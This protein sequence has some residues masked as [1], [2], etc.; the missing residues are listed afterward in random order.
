MTF[1]KF[2]L[3][4]C[5]ISFFATGCG[6]NSNSSVEQPSQNIEEGTNTGS[7]TN[8]ET[9]PEKEG[10]TTF[11]FSVNSNHRLLGGERRVFRYDIENEMLELSLPLPNLPLSDTSGSIPRY[12]NVTF[13]IDTVENALIVRFPLRNYLE[14]TRNPTELP[15][16][17]PLPGISGG[18]PPSFGFS[19]EALGLDAFG[20]AAVDSFSIYVETNLN[21]PFTLSTPLRTEQGGAEVGRIHLLASTANFNSGV[22]LTINL[23]RELSAII[24]DAQ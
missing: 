23:P 21:I 19:L 9:T 18:E 3:T 13:E 22:F 20:Y 6:S 16:G 8:E 17:R 12:P 14:L 1:S 5:L 10:E 4:L 24:A 7:N 11:L 15:T 2:L